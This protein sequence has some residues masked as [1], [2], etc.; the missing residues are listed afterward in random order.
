M[1]VPRTLRRAV[2]DRAR[3]RRSSP[4]RA[5]VAAGTVAAAAGGITYKALRR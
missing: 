2:A 4:V 5:L 3:G 1:A